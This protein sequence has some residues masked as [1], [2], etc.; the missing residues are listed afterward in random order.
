MFTEL[1]P[2]IDF[3]NYI[4]KPE[5]LPLTI[6]I[7]TIVVT[8]L[9]IGV[10]ILMYLL[11]RRTIPKLVFDGIWKEPNYKGTITCYYIKVKR[12]KGEGGTQEVMGF[13]GLK[14]KELHQ[15][16]WF[17]SKSK[18][19]KIT[20]HNYL[21]LFETF[22]HNGNEIIF[23]PENIFALYPQSFENNLFNQYKDDKLIV[24]IEASRARIDKRQITKKI[25]D[26][27]KEA[28]PILP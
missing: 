10:K 7:I 13:V 2:I 4:T 24:E 28:K 27:I 5:N 14:D 15:S 6:S 3:L 17:V 22:N 9:G 1:N 23:F 21:I 12:N 19:S 26:I 25:K 8:L 18:E 20:N 16:E 11:E